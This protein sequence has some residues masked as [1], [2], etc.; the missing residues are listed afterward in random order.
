MDIARREIDIG[1]RN[2]RPEQPWLAG[3]RT[4]TITYAAYGLDSAQG[5]IGSADDAAQTPSARWLTQTHGAEIVTRVNDP[6]LGLSLARAAV[7][8]IVLP[9]F[10]GDASDLPRQSDVIDA[11]THDEWLVSHHEARHQPPIRAA[12]D[13]LADYLSEPVRA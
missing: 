4:S 5:W 10:I 13:A 2:R 9:C 1:I 3:R 11:L 6:R 8:R 7:G 12:L